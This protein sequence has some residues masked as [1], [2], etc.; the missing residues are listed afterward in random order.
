M[1]QTIRLN[2]SDLHRMIKESVKQVL[3]ENI[4]Q[5]GTIMQT[6][7]AYMEEFRMG[8]LSD[9]VFHYEYNKPT[10]VINALLTARDKARKYMEMGADDADDFYNA[11]NNAYMEF[12]KKSFNNK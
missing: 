12:S 1:K 11:V 7:C 6:A 9:I 8:D 5:F 2:E 4:D 3:K 10:Q